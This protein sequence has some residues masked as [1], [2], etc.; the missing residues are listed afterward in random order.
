M[1]YSSISTKSAK[2]CHNRPWEIKM[3]GV[4][5]RSLSNT[6]FFLQINSW[7]NWCWGRSRFIWEG[8]QWV[9]ILL[10]PPSYQIGIKSRHLRDPLVVAS[11]TASSRDLRGRKFWE[12]CKF[13]KFPRSTLERGVIRF[14]KTSHS[15]SMSQQY[16]SEMFSYF[17]TLCSCTWAV[18][19]L[20]IRVNRGMQSMVW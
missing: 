5:L 17:L 6:S 20:K 15:H 2:E 16:E 9:L 1:R 11:F 13:R 14:M 7:L 4:L 8:Q 18:N 10:V 12:S 19:W 3:G